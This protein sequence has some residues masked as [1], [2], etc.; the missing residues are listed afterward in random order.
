[1]EHIE[2]VKRAIE[3]KKPDYL[4]LELV[5]V[6]G[7][8]NAYGTLNPETVSFIPG[9]EDFDSCWATYHWTFKYEGKNDKGEVLR[10]DEW[11]V[12]QKVPLEENSTYVVLENPLADK[13][14]LTNY[15]FPDIEI[16]LP[17]F[18]DLEKTIQRKYPDRFIC[19]YIDPGAFL[20]AYN[21]FGYENFFIRLIDNLDNVVEVMEGIFDYHYRMIPHWKN[22]GVHMVNIIDEIAGNKGLYFN[23]LLWRKYFKNFYERLFKQIH[24]NGLYTG[25]LLDGDISI[26]LDDLLS[27][28]IDVVQFVDVSSVGLKKIKETFKGKKCI[29]CSVGMLTTLAKGTP[30]DV[31]KEATTLVNELNDVSG[32]F[33]CNVLRWYRPQYPLENVL[34]SVEA[35]NRYRRKYA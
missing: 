8:Y 19:G 32:G 12:L 20:I 28:E 18:N 34:A 14:N 31:K 27:M 22:A 5:D 30:D 15:K 25:L 26:I 16:T 4:P 6:P 23:P 11:G 29:K 35:F 24:Q 1:M 7:I 13:E 21:L 17:F 2:T 9:T 10:R 3:F 33:I